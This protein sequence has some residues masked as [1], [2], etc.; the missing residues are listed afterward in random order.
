MFYVICC[1]YVTELTTL[2]KKII[3]CCYL[4]RD[5][6]RTQS[7]I[8]YGAFLPKYVTVAA[9]KYS[10]IDV[11]LSSTFFSLLVL[12]EIAMLSKCNFEHWHYSLWQKLLVSC[13]FYLF[14]DIITLDVI[15]NFRHSSK[16]II[17]NPTN[18]TVTS[19]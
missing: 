14:L 3:F 8:Y 12:E 17:Y 7:N 1:R 15:L 10:I 19:E 2:R 13:K 16:C 9:I 11:W 6:G 4:S 5:V 18:S